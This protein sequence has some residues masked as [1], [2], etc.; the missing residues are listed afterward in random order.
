MQRFW[1]AWSSKTCKNVLSVGSIDGLND[2]VDIAD[3]FRDRFS[4]CSV[5]A[6]STQDEL[7]TTHD[8][9]FLPSVLSVETVDKV[10]FS[11]MKSGKAA[12]YDNLSLE[13]IIHSH[14]SLICHLCKLFNMMLKHRYV[15]SEFGRGIIIP[16]V[17][18]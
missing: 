13:H 10:V 15:P 16:L 11:Q 5:S 6:D 14:P 8:D 12:G 17:K 2:N 7:I 1:R 9:S 18:D 3:V 4:A